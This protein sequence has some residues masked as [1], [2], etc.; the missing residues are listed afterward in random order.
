MQHRDPAFWLAF[1]IDNELSAVASTDLEEIEAD[2]PDVQFLA[3][4]ARGFHE[5]NVDRR[6]I[7]I[8]DLS[9]WL[10]SVGS[11]LSLLD[12]DLSYVVWRLEALLSDLRSATPTAV[13]CPIDAYRGG[14]VP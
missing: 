5:A 12:V 13:R 14:D 7:F 10:A 1:E 2:D 6:I 4:V 11:D 9:R 8:S 3:G